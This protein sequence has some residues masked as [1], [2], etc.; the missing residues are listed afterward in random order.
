MTNVLRAVA[1]LAWL[2]AFSPAQAEDAVSQEVQP[3]PD[4]TFEALDS[5]KE[6]KLSDYKGKAVLVV[7]TASECGFTS[8]Y[9]GLQK[10]WEDYGDKGL[11]VLGVPSNDFGGQEPGSEEEV[12]KFCEMRY[13]VTFPLTAKAVVKGKDAHPF[14][15]YARQKLGFIAAP[16]WNFHKYLIDARGELV[17]WFSSATSPDAEKLVKAVQHALPEE[18]LNLE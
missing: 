1:V 2:S 11:V 4:F 15:V 9:K 5:D 18:E 3:M 10:L 13:G 7:N 17:D 8:Q 12:K 14:Y 6:I 16:K